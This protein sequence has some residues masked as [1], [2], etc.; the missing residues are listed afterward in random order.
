MAEAVPP[1]DVKEL[2]NKYAES[3][4]HMTADQLHRFL[5]EVQGE[6][7]DLNARQIVEQVLQKRHHITKFVRHSLTLDDFH[8]YLF[9][10][11]LNPPIGSQV[12]TL[13]LSHC[14]V[15]PLF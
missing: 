15:A 8:H 10:P 6:S 4:A 12:P 1:S 2:F 5:V 7:G 9:S 13:S 11:E 3:G 14:L